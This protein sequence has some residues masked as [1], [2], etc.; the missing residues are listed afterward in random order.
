LP[1][2]RMAPAVARAGSR[3]AK[4]EVP[5]RWAR[6]SGDGQ[7]GTDC[8]KL[9]DGQADEH[10]TLRDAS[11]QEYEVEAGPQKA[12]RQATSPEPASVEGAAR[13]TCTQVG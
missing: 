11:A 1:P 10:V 12:N 3:S 4:D 7:A 5:E 8:A 2:L 6:G 13:T 9:Q